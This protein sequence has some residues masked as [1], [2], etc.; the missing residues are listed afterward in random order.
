MPTYLQLS[1]Q[2]GGTRFG[3]FPAGIVQLGTDSS[4]CQLVLSPMP[5]LA[6]VH[7]SITSMGGGRFTVQ[8]V[9]QGLQLFLVQRGQ[10]HLWPVEAPVTASQGDRVIVG[11]PTGPSFEL[12]WQDDVPRAAGPIASGPM[13]GM[14]G[15]A[16]GGAVGGGLASG[17]ASEM[18]R[19]A[20]SRM[21]RNAGPFRDLYHLYY[22]YRSGALRNPRVIVGILGT[23]FA[24][25]VTLA[26]GCSGL[27]AAVLF[28]D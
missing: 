11:G 2:Q 6:P 24:G 22:R 21:L 8:P 9:Q 25:F 13:A 4:H 3:P 14:G 7:A 20:M 16:L 27:V 28:G 12:Q 1:P 17:V 10:T 19:Q 15:A 26:T 18:Q 5:G 23:L